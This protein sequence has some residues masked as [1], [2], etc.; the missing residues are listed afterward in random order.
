MCRLGLAMMMSDGDDNGGEQAPRVS[1]L[2][3]NTALWDFHLV[4]GWVVVR[5]GEDGLL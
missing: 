1:Y 2:H 4:W 5:G 3:T